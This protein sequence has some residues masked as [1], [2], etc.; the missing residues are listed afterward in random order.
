MEKLQTTANAEALT[1]RLAS[2]I[3]ANRLGAARPLLSAVRRLAPPSPRLAE[4]ASRLAM[5]EG[6][7]DLAKTELDEAVTQAP[8][9]ASLRKCRADLRMQMGDKEGAAKDAAEAVV[10]D[11]DD[12][13]AKALLGVLMLELRRPADAI[14]CLAEAVGADPENPSYREGLAAAQEEVG[15]ADAALVTLTTGIAMAPRR[16][17]L[18]NAAILLSVRRRDFTMAVQL[19]DDARVAGMADACVFGLKGHAL[20][21]LGR[22]S[23][24]ADAYAEALK[25]GPNDP[26][27]RH[28][29]AASGTIP[30][31]ERAPVEYVRVVFDGYADRFEA[32]LLS[33]GYCVPGMIRS[34][35]LEHPVIA[36][37][38]RLGPALDLGC[39]TGLIAVVL[40]DLPIGPIVGVDVAPRMLA[41]AEKK[42]LYAELREADLMH[43][44]TEDATRWRLILAGDVLCYFGALG[45]VLA[46]VHARL[47]PHGWFVFTVE[48]LLPDYD[49]M[50]RGDGNWVLQRQGRYAHSEEYVAAVAQDLGFLIRKLERR[51]VRYEAEAPVAG[52]LVVLERARHDG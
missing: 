47:E 18:R 38:E 42:Q 25:L 41:H 39:G 26:Y 50:I 44:L 12:P 46:A 11:R 30:G 35:L 49:G 20:S 32:H 27:V 21:S 2:L 1:A 13:V 37:G 22:H 10:L 15:D 28:L 43:L 52:I 33:L 31:A 48:E 14:A 8:G 5:R 51:I 29:V 40:S 36:A 23:D 9:N 19:A 24:A 7:L 17:E 3:D 34:A 45:E 6:R 16:I 4:L